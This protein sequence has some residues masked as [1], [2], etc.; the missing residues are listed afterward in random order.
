MEG[1]VETNRTRD[2]RRGRCFPHKLL[3]HL[4]RGLE[5]ESL[6]TAHI[7]GERKA[8]GPRLNAGRPKNKSPRSHRNKGRAASPNR[9][10]ELIRFPAEDAPVTELWVGL[11][12]CDFRQPSDCR[13]R[14]PS[15][16]TRWL[17]DS[18]WKAANHSQWRDRTG[19]SP[20]FP[21]MPNRAPKAGIAPPTENCDGAPVRIAEGAKRVKLSN[22]PPLTWPIDISL[23]P[24]LIL[25]GVT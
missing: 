3:S 5:D 24:S 16:P 18:S 17:S 25:N 20:D 12:A 11:L 13:R 21:V 6:G 8:A 4:S 10:L 19:F 22:E 23:P 15:S 14:F 1:Q 2:E 7:V 9:L